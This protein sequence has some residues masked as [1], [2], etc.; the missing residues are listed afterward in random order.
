M[1]AKLSKGGDYHSE[2]TAE[3]FAHVAAAVARRE[4]AIHGGEGLPTIKEKFKVER[5]QAKAVNF[6]IIYG[7]EASTLGEDLGITTPEAEKLVEAW[8][9]SKPEVKRWKREAIQ[10]SVRK[11]RAL[12][13]LGRWRTLPLIDNPLYRRRS[14]RAAVNFRIQGSAADVVISAMLRVWRHPKL[15]EMGF[16][17]VLQVHDELVLEGPQQF[18]EEA[19]DLVRQLMLNPF[20]DHK[21][22]FQFLALLT[23]DVSIGHSF[24][25]TEPVP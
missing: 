9:S 10:E 17:L 15:M 25:K 22:S 16:R 19:A 2:V 20:A 23:A 21:P 13:L 4:V 7:M 8:Y 12:S 6:G 24:S 1:L 14:E 3:M 18:A 11:G 5:N